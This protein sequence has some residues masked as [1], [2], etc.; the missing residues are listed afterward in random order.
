MTPAVG[1]TSAGVPASTMEHKDIPRFSLDDPPPILADV[2]WKLDTQRPSLEQG[3]V[4]LGYPLPED[5]LDEYGIHFARCL[6]SGIHF[7]K[8]KRP[9]IT[10][11]DVMNWLSPEGGWIHDKFIKQSKQMLRIQS[12]AERRGLLLKQKEY[13][14]QDFILGKDAEK[15]YKVDTRFSAYLCNFL[16]EYDTWYHGLEFGSGKKEK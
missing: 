2:K 10:R 3:L 12:C 9:I 4:I 14:I 1:D 15:A 7:A 8:E 5:L 11:A 16:S 6:A 13:Y